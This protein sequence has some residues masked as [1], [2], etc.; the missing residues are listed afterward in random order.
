MDL[1]DYLNFRGLNREEKERK[2]MKITTKEKRENY[3]QLAREPG[4]NNWIHF[5]WTYRITDNCGRVY[6]YDNQILL[7]C[8][9]FKGEKCPNYEGCEQ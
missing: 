6:T 1:I 8:V 4:A 5:N 9:Q 3:I 7:P 2:K